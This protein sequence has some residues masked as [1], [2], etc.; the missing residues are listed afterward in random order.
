MGIFMGYGY[1]EVYDTL[2][3]ILH[4]AMRQSRVYY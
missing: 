3:K 4:K 2:L 1:I